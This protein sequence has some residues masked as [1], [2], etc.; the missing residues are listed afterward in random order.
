MRHVDAVLQD[1]A[2]VSAVHQALSNRCPKSGSHGRPGYPAEIVLRLLILKH[3]RNWSYAVLEREVPEQ[4]LKA[5]VERLLV[6][7]GRLPRPFPGRL[8]KGSNGAPSLKRKSV[9]IGDLHLYN[10]GTAACLLGVRPE[11]LRSWRRRGFGPPYWE[12]KA[13]GHICCPFEGLAAFCDRLTDQTC[14]T[15]RR[16]RPCIQASR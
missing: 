5:F 10:A 7:G 1:E 13:H 9:P 8:P 15:P 2:I 11:T 6:T 4:E 16:C 12:K 14:K 3:V